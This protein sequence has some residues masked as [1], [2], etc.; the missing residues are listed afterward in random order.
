MM[1]LTVGTI[2]KIILG[3]LVVAAVAYGLYTFFSSRV[4]GSF[5]NIGVNVTG[6]G[7]IVKS[8]MTIY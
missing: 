2:I 6:T 3:I 8:L 1:E 7:N 5:D 4:L